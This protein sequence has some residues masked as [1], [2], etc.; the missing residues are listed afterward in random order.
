M[1]QAHPWQVVVGRNLDSIFMVMEYVEHDLKGLAEGMRQPF[2]TAEARAPALAAC[3]SGE[4]PQ[5]PG[6]GAAWKG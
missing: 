3:T 4:N 6:L 5:L 1:R 2:T